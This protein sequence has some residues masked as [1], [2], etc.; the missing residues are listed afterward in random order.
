MHEDIFSTWQAENNTDVK[1][2]YIYV[3][4]KKNARYT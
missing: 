3:R 1:K 2:K 4:E